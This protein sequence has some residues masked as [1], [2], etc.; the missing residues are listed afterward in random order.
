MHVAVVSEKYYDKNNCYLGNTGDSAVTMGR[1]GWA[2]AMARR[3]VRDV[4]MFKNVLLLP[5]IQDMFAVCSSSALVRFL[6][7]HH[8][9]IF[10]LSLYFSAYLCAYLPHILADYLAV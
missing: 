8:F 10:F 2:D 4:E 5:I 7:L 9:L 3:R 6:C 1:I